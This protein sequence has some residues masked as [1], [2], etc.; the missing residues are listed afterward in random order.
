LQ[1]A[2]LVSGVIHALLLW[3]L[4]QFR[5]TVIFPQSLTQFVVKLVD[6]LSAERGISPVMDRPAQQQ[7]AASFA[8]RK[9]AVLSKDNAAKMEGV[10]TDPGGI[11]V[12][13]PSQC[14]V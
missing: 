1:W 5:F 6:V 9:T 8:S 4:W 2:I 13:G 10:V 3:Q 11:A 14:S 7:Q 12:G